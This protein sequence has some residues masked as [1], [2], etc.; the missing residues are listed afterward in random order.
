MYVNYPY[1][2]SVRTVIFRTITQ[3]NIT[4]NVG[5]YTQWRIT[6]DFLSS[7]KAAQA[8]RYP[9][10]T[11]AAELGGD[12]FKLPDSFCTRRFLFF[13]NLQNKQKRSLSA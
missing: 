2:F 4:H 5:R 8:K 9:P 13:Q 10:K 1:D 12:C 7:R 6:G 11:T 3:F